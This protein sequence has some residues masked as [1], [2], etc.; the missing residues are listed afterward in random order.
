MGA[1]IVRAFA[2]GALLRTWCAD[3]SAEFR[4]SVAL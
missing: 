4:I 1:A 3:E 2:E